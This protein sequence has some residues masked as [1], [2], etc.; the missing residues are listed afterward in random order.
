MRAEANCQARP[1]GWRLGV[2]YVPVQ[3]PCRAAN[4]LATIDYGESPA[5]SGP[6]PCYLIGNRQ[7]ESPLR[8]IWTSD[9]CVQFEWHREVMFGRTD[10][11]LVGFAQTTDLDPSLESAT[12][13]L[14][15]RLLDLMRE[16]GYGRLLRVWNYIP[17]INRREG[18]LE[19][20]QRFCIGRHAAF[21]ADGRNIEHEAPAASA[22]GHG[23]QTVA[24]FF[25]ATR[26]AFIAIENPRQVSAY[27]Y[28]PEYGPRSP[29]FSRAVLS[30]DEHGA[31]AQLFVSGTASVVGHRSVHDDAAAQT[32]ETLLNL[33]A[34]VKRA[35]QHSR[36]P[37]DWNDAA[38]LKIYLRH[39]EDLPSV[40]E[41]V[42]AALPH[43]PALF[44]EADICRRELRLEIEGVWNCG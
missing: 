7:L 4:V 27:R 22:V 3:A 18:G 11:Y 8:E 24:I 15:R 25:I 2:E 37:I 40:K 19:R 38:A 1:H 23:E 10:S 29:S 26:N 30:S 32:E 17:D 35:Q 44:L 16:R 43:T 6:A 14:L 9:E 28:P 33:R 31:R 5:S 39:A 20:Y 42:D 41:I 21:I 12:Q 34:L 36:A 13:A